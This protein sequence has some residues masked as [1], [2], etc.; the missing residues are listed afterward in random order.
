MTCILMGIAKFSAKSNHNI[1]QL[2]GLPVMTTAIDMY[3][4][5]EE[6]NSAIIVSRWQYIYFDASNDDVI[7]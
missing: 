5:H 3:L 7:W 4:Q 6:R 1:A 2:Q